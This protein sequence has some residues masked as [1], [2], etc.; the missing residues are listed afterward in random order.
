MSASRT[1]RRLLRLYPV[2][3]RDRYGEELAELIVEA[4]G[5]HGVSWRVRL[6]V[7]RAG[8]RERLRS[9]GLSGDVAP[10]DRARGGVVL[11]LCAWALAVVGAA[12][13]QKFSEHWLEATPVADRGVPSAAFAGLVASGLCGA[14]LVLAGI[15]CSMP[16]V[17]AFLRRGGW[18]MIQRR[19]GV[20]I[21]LTVTAAAATVALVVW[22]HGL[23][24]RRRDGTDA[25]YAIAF[26]G[27][28]CLLIASLVGW[29]A[30]AVA[31]VR[32]LNLRASMLRRQTWLGCG[33]TA[34]MS[35]MVVATIIWW[36]SVASVAPWFLSGRSEGAAPAPFA[37]QLVAGF[38][39]MLVA[40]AL[41]IMGSRHA[42]GGIYGES[43][44]RGPSRGPSVSESHSTSENLSAADTS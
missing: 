16:R 12:L 44:H 28:V 5:E 24:P 11:V 8:G 10:I 41:G 35:G 36:V 29:T 30:T 14:A 26:A 6:D 39:L 20:A 18:V 38:L 43:D 27:W 3:W 40:S 7:A 13:V 32:R 17:F 23:T 9:A 2:G 22:A 4:S 31:I 19:T 25:L 37:P 1:A 34:A 42:L 33:V 21:A 15:G